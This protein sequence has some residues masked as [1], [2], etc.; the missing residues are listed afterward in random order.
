KSRADNVNETVAETL[1]RHEKQ[2]QEFA[3]R[4]LGRAIP[5]TYIYRE[6][7]SG[8]TIQ[9][10]PFMQLLLKQLE[11]KQFKGVLVMEPQ[12]LSRGDMLDCGTIVHAFRYTETLIVT[13][14]KTYNLED[15]YDRKF[16]EME[17]SRGNDYLEYTKEI[18]QRGRIASVKEGQF[19]GNV[20]PY[21]YRRTSYKA[22]NGRIFHTLEPDP[23]EAD[24]V[25]YIFEL[26][27]QG[28]GYHKIC[29]IL[30]SLN[31]K[32]RNLD[33]WSLTSLKDLLQNPV[34]IG[35][36][37]WNWRKTVV[38]YQDGNLKKS[39]PK[40]DANDCII[41]D[42]KHPALIS[43]E[44]FQMAQS[45]IDNNPRIHTECKLTNPLAGL[46][47]CECG[48][49][50]IRK[51]YKNQTKTTCLPRYLCTNQPICRT[52]SS[53]MDAIIDAVIVQMNEQVDDFKL[54]LDNGQN[55]VEE[56]KKSTINKLK[57][58]LEELETQETKQ[59]DLLEKGI[60]SEDIFMLRR[61]QLLKRRQELTD[62]ISETQKTQMKI[63]DFNERITSFEAAI[64]A[65]SNESM[66]AEDKNILLK[67]CIKKITYHAS[68]YEG[69]KDRTKHTL[70][71]LD[72]EPIL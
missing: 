68:K 6:V 49:A 30:N 45:R 70:F 64:D 52:Q 26:Y 43:D 48:K 59:F 63:I 22:E 41:V 44:T 35:K 18:L 32:P 24:A 60:Y 27:L 69:H 2:L 12:R 33:S 67:K 14:M 11:T 25:R 61:N 3:K 20:A 54:K 58:E 8:E 34:Y 21:G 37:R 56:L 47:F 16:F 72:I 65:L 1:A 62:Q 10:R 9:D 28:Y 50:M 39:R 66:S 71:T 36:I 13:P 31:I 4:E 7:V 17:L 40:S 55:N 29:H 53:T 46:L 42:G 57:A 19:I 5:E 23:I 15:K 38:S 51:Q